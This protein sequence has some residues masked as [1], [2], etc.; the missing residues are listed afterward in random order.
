[1]AGLVQLELDEK[2]KEN[3]QEMQTQMGQTQQELAALTTKA[4]VRS[5]ESK[6]AQLTLAELA[7]LP[8][9]TRTFEQVGKMFLLKPLSD[10]KTKLGESATGG[11]KEAAALT[12]KKAQ[13]E[14]SL[15]KLQEDFQ[16]FVKAHM[17]EAKEEGADKK[18]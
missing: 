2:D 10:V 5:A 14:D 9:E 4:R 18:E 6:H 8:E 11:E 3:F 16:E 7:E 1:M 17:V 12:E 13:M 15:K